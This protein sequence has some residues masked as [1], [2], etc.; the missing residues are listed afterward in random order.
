MDGGDLAPAGSDA[1]QGG[2]VPGALRDEGAEREG[3]A[4]Q[5]NGDGDDAEA[6]YSFQLESAMLSSPPLVT[7]RGV[8]A[9][10]LTL[11]SRAPRAVETSA[12][13]LG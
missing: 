10:P 8:A 7:R 12:R 3:D 6:Q 11:K 4:K 2:D 5:G 9:P 13:A 1:P